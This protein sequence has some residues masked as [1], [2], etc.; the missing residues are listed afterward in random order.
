MS[1]RGKGGKGLG[2]GGAEKLFVITFRILPS[3][4]SDNLPEEEVL[5]I[6]MDL[7]PGVF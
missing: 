3:L 2:K 4:L 6:S 1:G 7:K 5:N